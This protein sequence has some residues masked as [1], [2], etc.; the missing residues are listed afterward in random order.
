[1]VL[2]CHDIVGREKLEK[3]KFAGSGAFGYVYRAR[4]KVWKYVVA[5]KILKD[6]ARFTALDKEVEHMDKASCDYVLSVC[7]IFEGFPPYEG[8]SMTRGIITKYMDKGSVQTLLDLPSPPPWPLAVRLVHEVALGMNFLHDKKLLHGDLKPS[9]VLLNEDLHAKLADFGLSRVS[10]SASNSSREATGEVG[11]T[12]VYMPPEALL[13]HFIK[14]HHSF[15]VY[16]Y[17]IFMWSVF[18]GKEPFPGACRLLLEENVGREKQRPPCHKLKERNEK[19]L[20]KLVALMIRCWDQEPANRP[21]FGECLDDTEEVYLMHEAKVRKAVDEVLDSLDPHSNTSGSIRQTQEQSEPHDTVDNIRAG[22]FSR[23]ES[24]TV[25]TETMSEAAKAKF[26]DDN[27][28]VLIQEVSNVMAIVQELGDMVPREIRKTI[29]H[30]LND[31]EKM[32]ELFHT[33]LHSGGETVKAAFY[34]AL[35]IHESKLVKQLSTISS[36]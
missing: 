30:T 16:S 32:R 3:W 10:A 9:N 7:G 13:D 31:E 8:S 25:S 36:S 2:L 28:L 17:G 1:M 20:K 26:V 29:E 35:K 18:T 19:G 4:H 12:S 27:I 24:D 5:I 23:Q 15:D 22:M 14:P 11:G 34:T 6:G 21:A 33:A